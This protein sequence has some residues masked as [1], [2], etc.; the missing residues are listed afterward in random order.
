MSVLLCLGKRYLALF[1][2][3]FSL[4]RKFWKLVLTEGRGLTFKVYMQEKFSPLKRI[5]FCISRVSAVLGRAPQTRWWGRGFHFI[6]SLTTQLVMRRWRVTGCW[7]LWTPLWKTCR[8]LWSRTKL[9]KKGNSS[10]FHFPPAAK[11]TPWYKQNTFYSLGAPPSLKK[12]KHFT[13]RRG[14]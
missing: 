3:C 13:E 8:T 11:G 9:L 14:T 1:P 10:T 5:F 4:H 2:D 6:S 12:N 7:W